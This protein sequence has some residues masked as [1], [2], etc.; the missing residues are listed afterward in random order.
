MYFK[1]FWNDELT[2]LTAEQTN[3]Y[4]FQKL[5]KTI[6]V[7]KE[8]T[9]QFISIQMYLSILKLPTYHLYWSE[10]MHYAPVADLMSRDRYKNIRIYLHVADNT[11]KDNPGNTGKKLYRVAPVIDHVKQNCNKIEPG[12]YQSIDEQI[13]PAKTRFSRIR[14]YNP[15]KPTKW[16]FKNFVRSGSSGIMYGFLFYTGATGNEK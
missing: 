12:Q 8:E 1:I 7:T 4:S 11:M 10:E 6:Q 13:V 9:E 16:D 15:K 2:G 14:Q 5:R 3:I